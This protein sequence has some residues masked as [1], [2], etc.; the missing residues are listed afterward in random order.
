MESHKGA[1]L[2][3][4]CT[5]GKLKFISHGGR[6]DIKEHF[7]SKEHSDF[8]KRQNITNYKNC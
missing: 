2:T 6:L 5:M 4:L 1:M 7:N 3:T 8:L